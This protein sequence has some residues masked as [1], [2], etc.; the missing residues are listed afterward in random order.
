MRVASAAG[1]RERMPRSPSATAA[2][3]AMSPFA[4][5]SRSW[6]REYRRQLLAN[7]RHRQRAVDD[8]APLRFGSGA[9]EIGRAYALEKFRLLP[10]ELVQSAPIREPLPPDADGNIENKR[11]VRSEIIECHALHVADQR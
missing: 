1:G 6:R 5:E 8:P 4:G 10:L 3:A 11:H 7:A 9:R 2:T